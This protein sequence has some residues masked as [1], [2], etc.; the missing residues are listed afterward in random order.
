MS[1]IIYYILIYKEIKHF[2]LI[3][4]DCCLVAKLFSF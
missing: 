3:L 2:Y 1:Q 4:L